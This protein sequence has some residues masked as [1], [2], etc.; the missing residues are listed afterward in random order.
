MMEGEQSV[1]L[2]IAHAGKE[3]ARLRLPE[4]EWRAE[5]A[6]SRRFGIEQAGRVEILGPC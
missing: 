5:G 2:C 6:F 1:S 3:R 4:G